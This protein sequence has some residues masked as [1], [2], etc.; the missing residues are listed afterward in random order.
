M[1]HM[2]RCI[3]EKKCCTNTECELLRADAD[4]GA[5]VTC[6]A[7]VPHEVQPRTTVGTRLAKQTVGQI[8]SRQRNALV[9]V[10]SNIL[11]CCP[12]MVVSAHTDFEVSSSSL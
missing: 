5:T 7:T 9:S 8:V 2:G 1:R 11:G 4:A 3:L 6:D 12:S 10:S